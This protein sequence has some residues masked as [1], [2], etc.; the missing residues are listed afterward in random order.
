MKATF[1]GRTGYLQSQATECAEHV[2]TVWCEEGWG[3]R[4]IAE[5]NLK[6]PELRQEHLPAR[7]VLLHQLQRQKQHLNK[8]TI[9]SAIAQ[10]LYGYGIFKGFECKRKYTADASNRTR[11]QGSVYITLYFRSVCVLDSYLDYF[12]LNMYYRPIT[13]QYLFTVDLWHPNPYVAL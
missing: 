2:I 8:S 1:L 3:L 6:D 13:K 7:G 11:L 10:H 9:Q 5:S 4:K 12:Y